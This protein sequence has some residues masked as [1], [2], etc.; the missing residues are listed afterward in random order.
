M[1]DREQVSLSGLVKGG[2]LRG[3]SQAK[4][5]ASTKPEDCLRQCGS[6]NCTKVSAVAGG[7]A[8]ELGHCTF[9]WRAAYDTFT[10]GFICLESHI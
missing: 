7:L 5:A 6:L 9:S 4:K 8:K 3:S 10:L 1:A 2:W